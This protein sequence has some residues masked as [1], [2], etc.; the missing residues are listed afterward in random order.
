MARR[1]T[2]SSDIARRYAP[3]ALGVLLAAFIIN[4]LFTRSPEQAGVYNAL[5]IIALFF[6]AASA[7]LLISAL[8]GRREIWRLWASLLG[9]TVG[10]WIAGALMQTFL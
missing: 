7:A 2:E 10:I 5:T 6:T 8:L 4:A 3:I 9:A 1:P